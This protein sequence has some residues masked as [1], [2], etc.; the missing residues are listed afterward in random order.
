MLAQDTTHPVSPPPTQRTS[1]DS[2]EIAKSAPPSHRAFAKEDS[3]CALSTKDWI[4]SAIALFAALVAFATLVLSFYLARKRKEA[5]LRAEHEFKKRIELEERQRKIDE[6]LAL[7]VAGRQLAQQH[8]QQVKAQKTKTAE[9]RY[10]YIL[11]N[12]VCLIHLAAPGVEGVPVSLADT[13]VRLNISEHYRG[14]NFPLLSEADRAR[15]EHED[16]KPEDVLQRAFQEYQRKLL[17]IIGD[18][19]SGKTTLLKYYA[20]CCLQPD[21]YRKLGFHQPVFPLYLPL[22]EV[23]PD[24]SL[25]DNLSHWA[26]KHDPW[27]P[28]TEF[29]A[30][31]DERDT[32]V[33]LD[34]LDEVSKLDD[35]RRVCA[36]IDN[37]CIGLRRVRFVFTSRSTGMRR[38]DNLVLRTPHLHAE[39]RDFS[40][41]QKQE[42][43]RKWFRAAHLEGSH[44]RKDESPD[45][46]KVRQLREAEKS[47]Q[48]V[49]DYL[50]QKENRSLRELA[51]IPMLLQLLAL[52]WKQYKTKPESRTKLYDVALD[53]LLEH[54]D[55]QR[56]LAPL[57]KAEKARR[58]LC[59]AALW[60]QE[61]LGA[62]EV[63][64]AKLHEYLQPILEPINHT[65]KAEELCENLRDRAGLI[66]DYGKNEYIFR[67]KSFR[68]YFAGLQLA[69]NYQENDRLTRLVK[70]FG[71]NAWAE[72][73]RYFMSKTDRKAFNTFM[74]ALFDSAT[75]RE[76]S[77]LQQD[78]LQTL[79]REAA[80]KP[81]EALL[82]CLHDAGKNEMQQRYALD[83]LKAIGGERV[84]EALLAFTQINSGRAGI[85]EYAAEI[86]AQLSVTDALRTTQ[87]PQQ[88]LFEELPESFRNPVEYNAEYILIRAG[89][90]R[91]SVTKQIDKVP[92]IYFAKY[93]VTNK[94]YRRF[95]RYLRGEDAESGKLFA[96]ELFS[97]KLLEFAASDKAYIEHL[98]HDDKTWPQKLKSA[99]DD[100]RKFN[101]EDQPVVDVSWYA[102]RAYCLWL[103]ELERASNGQATGRKQGASTIYRLP[104]EV[105]WERAAAGRQEDGSLREYPWPKEKGEPNKKLANY[106]RNI[107]QTTP[108]NRYPEGAT[109]EGLMDMAGNVREWQENWYDA[110]KTRRALRGGSWYG[111][112]VEL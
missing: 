54:R 77:Q 74:T 29:H 10:R 35:R 23:D 1:A 84:R 24:Q 61:E 93:P 99:C 31:L 27:I 73:L 64:K 92:D 103:S 83:C 26:K 59:P 85:R 30:W 38:D 102:A 110:E 106:E 42:F 109:P 100:D 52:I 14:E 13:F 9:E 48:E 98:G 7:Q 33:L 39:V 68:E 55:D 11:E 67:H 96:P 58:V 37:R 69:A 21:G 57:L 104:R 3:T 16:L 45:D 65:L 18:P 34:G 70:T 78:L 71:D 80:E 75:S 108:V 6:H 32:L 5:E 36:W 63:A 2:G 47:A 22:H 97:E 49:I 60:M 72:P 19:G 107:G 112:T 89:T 25:A 94:Q 105:E 76:L 82:A 46:W 20:M 40:H 28:A 91:Y 62:E 53:Y 15:N 56:G 44:P 43:L 4:T 95:I 90:I 12:E 8:E 87:P 81:L 101:G 86:A 88:R 51:G 41:E 17:L 66:A 111:Y 79:V 50:D